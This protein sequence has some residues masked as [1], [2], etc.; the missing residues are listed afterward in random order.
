METERG[1][2]DKILKIT[3]TIQEEYPELSKYLEEMP[4]TITNENN[5]G[6]NI[7]NLREYYYSLNSLVKNYAREHINCAK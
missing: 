1:L 5:S 4:D 7:K 2:N 3:M 6:I